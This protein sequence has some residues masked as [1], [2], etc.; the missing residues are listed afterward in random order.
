MKQLIYN[1]GY[2]MKEVKTIFRS[3][4]LSNIFSLVSTSLIFFVLALVLSGWWVSSQVME[5]IQ[6]EAEIDI[7]LVEG[8]NEPDTVYKLEEINSIKGIKAARVVDAE[9]AYDRM[10]KILGKEAKVLAYFDDNPFSSF[11]EVQ[12]DLTQIDDIMSQL[13]QMKDIEHVRDNREV[14]DRLSQIAKVFSLLGYLVVAAVGV[15]TLVI[16][17][18]IIR[19]GIYNN[20]DQINTLQLLGAPQVF[21]AFPF[22]IEGFLVTVAGG[23]LACGLTAFIIKQ[24]Y[25]QMVAPLPFIPLPPREILLKSIMGIVMSLSALLGI[26]GSLFGIASSKE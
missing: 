12:I 25:V 23:L 18:H 10:V 17:S 7:Y 14:L 15:S 24:V 5:T 8:L 2:F 16:I 4:L 9:E 1:M 21:I 22:L 6:G 13:G 3:N 19:Q 11:I 26:I 20:R